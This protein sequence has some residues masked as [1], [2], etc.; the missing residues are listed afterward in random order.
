MGNQAAKVFQKCRWYDPYPR[1]S[2]ALKLLSLAPQPV[3]ARCWHMILEET[4]AALSRLLQDASAERTLDRLMDGWLLEQSA[5]AE[6]SGERRRPLL[7]ETENLGLRAL[8]LLKNSPDAVKGQ[9]TGKLLAILT[10]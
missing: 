4:E 8:L 5:D 10:E 7:A 6:L 2:F 1:L 9:V 3:R